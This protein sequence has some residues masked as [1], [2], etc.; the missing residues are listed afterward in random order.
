MGPVNFTQVEFREEANTAFK[1]TNKTLKRKPFHSA[2]PR[3]SL[4][5]LRMSFLKVQTFPEP[6][7]TFHSI[8]EPKPSTRKPWEAENVPQIFFS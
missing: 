2:V 4:C 3:M 7:D 8:G 1:C 5:R 6:D